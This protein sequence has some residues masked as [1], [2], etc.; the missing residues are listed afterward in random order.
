[1]RE[2]KSLF[3]LACQ[4]AFAV[5]VV[6]ALATSAAGVVELDI[7]PPTGGAALDVPATGPSP[8]GSLVDSAPVRPKVRNVRITTGATSGLDRM[9]GHAPTARRSPQK[10][11]VVSPAEKVSGY[12]TVGATWAPG[13]EFSADQ[14]RISVRTLD[15]GSWSE[16][17]PVPYDPDHEP[18]PGTSPGVARPGTDAMVV[19]AVD[20]VKVR[21]I[22]TTGA[23]P[24]DL[25]GGLVAPGSARG[26]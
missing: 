9:P 1:M 19:G 3:V 15:N 24:R 12:A 11:R 6:A 2:H 17:Q 13:Q 21:A 20:K 4:Q 25:E 18:D 16:W 10:I 8:S 26:R 7:V 5:A 23:A 22:S 14:I